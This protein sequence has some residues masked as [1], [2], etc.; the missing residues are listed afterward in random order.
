MRS[1]AIFLMAGGLWLAGAPA[2]GQT[3]TQ[4]VTPRYKDGVARVNGQMVQLMNGKMVPMDKHITLPDGTLVTPDGTVQ[5]PNGKN[6]VLEEGMAINQSGR[7]VIFK[8]DMFTTDVIDSASEEAGYQQ[9]TVII[10][11]NGETIIRKE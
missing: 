10:N 9:R 6:H 11:N 1:L 4:A 2:Q 7:V 8:D 3:K 5:P